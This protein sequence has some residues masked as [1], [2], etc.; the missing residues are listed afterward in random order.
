VNFFVQPVSQEGAALEFDGMFLRLRLRLWLYRALPFL[1]RWGEY[2]PACCGTCPTC[3]GATATGASITWLGAKR[4]P[5][6]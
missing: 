6:D 4:S 2:A 5:E 1:E 3:L